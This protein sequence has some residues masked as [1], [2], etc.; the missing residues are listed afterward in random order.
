VADIAREIASQPAIWRRAAEHTGE[1]AR[2]LPKRGGRLAAI[3][4]G[5]SYYVAQAIAGL[6]ESA[7]E[8]ESDAFPASELPAQRRY[9]GVLAV[10]RSGRTTELLRALGRLRNGTPTVAICG[11]ADTEVART[12]D[13]ATILD[14]ADEQAIVQTRFA[15]AVLALMRSLY[16]DDLETIAAEAE[17]A[18][19]APLPDGRSD[20]RRWVFLSSGWSVGL[21]NE[22]ALKMR[23]A[24]GAWA[25]AYP[26]TEYLHGPISATPPATVV[27]AFGPVERE[28]LE[29]AMR[30][31]ATV[32]DS[33]RDP[34]AELVLVQRTAVALAEEQ[35]LDPGKPRHLE[36]AVVLK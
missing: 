29:S 18:L 31:G 33:G 12:V 30:A 6:R 35:G 26:A 19:E 23:E 21:A 8:G 17:D 27:W 2:Y 22:A 14:F 36:R 28:V 3:G 25:E 13:H 11:V 16:R 10:S 34:M 24:A 15:T 1:V 32:I 5:T 20:V 9:D 7:D 4:C